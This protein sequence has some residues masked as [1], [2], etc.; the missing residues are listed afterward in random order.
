MNPS[1]QALYDKLMAFVIDEPGVELTFARRL[2]RENGWS[3]PYAERVIVEYKRF[4]FLAMTAG[5]V[6]TP[7]EQVDQAWHLHLTYTRSYWDGLCREV[8]GQPLHHGPTKGGAAEQAKFIDLYNQTLASYRRFFGQEPP[9]DIW[10]PA[11]Q[12]FGEDLRHVS[13]NTARN[14][15]VPKPRLPAWPWR[16]RRDGVG[17]LCRQ[18]PPLQ[19]STLA[20]KTPDP[21]TSAWPQPSRAQPRSTPLFALGLVGLPLAAGLGPLDWKGDE[22]LGFYFLAA[23]AA[24]L[25][26]LLIR[27]IFT[28]DEPAASGAKQAPLDPYQIACLAGGPMRAVQAAFAAMVQAGTLKLA[29]EESTTLGVFKRRQTKIQQGGTSLPENAPRLERALYHAA[30]VPVETIA[31]LTEAGLPVAEDI[32]TDL[33]KRGLMRASLIRTSSIVASAIMAAP[34]LLG[35]TK[36]AIGLWRDRPVGFLIAACAVTGIVAVVMLLAGSRV[37]SAGRQ[38]LEPL[39]DKHAHTKQLV[40][41]A[42]ATVAPADLA[43][44]VGLFGCSLLAAGQLASVHAM[45]PRTSGGG[46]CGSAGCGGGGCGGGGCSGGCG[47]GCGGCG[48]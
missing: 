14:W 33:V 29:S 45:L 34:L 2:A 27:L 41:T 11:G 8:L 23:A 5:Q 21:R 3:L 18:S 39:Q 9:A 32:R 7:S 25:A 42:S 13:V 35:V 48:G 10:S 17:S 44:L 46:G 6:A 16:A 38:I 28:G 22:F 4:V 20:A 12:R 15:I 36:I 40:S 1:Q 43:L 37:T 47:G 31:P 24:F 30:V 19:T 26:A